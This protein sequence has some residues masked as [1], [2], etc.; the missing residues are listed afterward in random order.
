MFGKVTR[1]SEA[2]AISATLTIDSVAVYE[3]RS[4]LNANGQKGHHEY[5]I[6]SWPADVQRVV[7]L[8]DER[9]GA[10]IVVRNDPRSRFLA[11]RLQ[12]GS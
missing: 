3:I 5:D 7:A 10:G 6:T 2:V 1:A 9:Y 4:D 11:N 12:V 8:C